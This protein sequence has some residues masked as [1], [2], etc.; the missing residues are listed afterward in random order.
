MPDNKQIA[1]LSPDREPNGFFKAGN[2][3][4]ANAR[5]GK[6]RISEAMLRQFAAEWDPDDASTNVMLFLVN[7]MS[8]KFPEAEFKDRIAS[9]KVLASVLFPKV[10]TMQ[11]PEEVDEDP[12]AWARAGAANPE[13]RRAIEKMIEGMGAEVTLSREVAVFTRQQDSRE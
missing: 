4:A 7:T 12:G 11:E 5:R 8:G 9:A 3:L 10:H 1:V 2:Q 13:L 6:Q